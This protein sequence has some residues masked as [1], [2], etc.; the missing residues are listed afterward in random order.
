[1]WREK[2]GARFWGYWVVRP[3]IVSKETH[4]LLIMHIVRHLR[5]L[6][7]RSSY[8]RKTQVV[9]GGQNDRTGEVWEPRKRKRSVHRRVKRWRNRS[10]YGYIV[11]NDGTSMAADIGR[12]V[13]YFGA[14]LVREDPGESSGLP[15]SEISESPGEPALWAWGDMG[16]LDYFD[17]PSEPV[18]RRHGYRSPAVE[19]PPVRSRYDL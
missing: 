4:E 16:T 3:L 7:D 6:A 12:I 2:P 10:G 9:K 11:V 19:A 13:S 8:S 14:H 17:Q 1:M 5:A 18:A 15:Y